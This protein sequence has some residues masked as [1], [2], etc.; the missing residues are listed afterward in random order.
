MIERNFLLVD[1]D[2]DDVALIERVFRRRPGKS[3]LHHVGDARA[4]V[5]YLEG[6]TANG[7]SRIMPDVI[8]LDLKMP[9]WNGF[10][11][12]Q[13]LHSESSRD[14]RLIPVI[15]LSSSTLE[16]DVVRAYQLGVNAY[17]CKS[18]SWPVFEE[19]LETLRRFW[20][21]EVETPQLRE[22]SEAEGTD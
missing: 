1:D 15:V 4:A 9:G 22:R 12:L 6:S 14:L 10:D 17:L 18:V 11:F 20:G 3:R 2:L 8:L 5:R 16:E 7:P 21:E 13:W 19:R